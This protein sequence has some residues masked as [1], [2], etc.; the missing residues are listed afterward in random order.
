MRKVLILMKNLE[1][2]RLGAFVF[3]QDQ[4]QALSVVTQSGGWKPCSHVLS[5]AS[6]CSLRLDASVRSRQQLIPV[7]N[8]F[9][10]HGGEADVTPGLALEPAAR[11]DTIG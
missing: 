3:S 11:R 4:L 5:L 7:R 2:S 1:P 9:G 6:L 10:D 8:R